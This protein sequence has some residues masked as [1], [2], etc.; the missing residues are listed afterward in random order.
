MSPIDEISN[1]NDANYI[2]EYDVSYINNLCRITPVFK[3][4]LR[5]DIIYYKPDYFRM[6]KSFS[7]RN[8]LL[9]VIIK[10]ANK[11]Y[12]LNPNV[13]LSNYDNYGDNDICFDQYK[14]DA[15]PQSPLYRL[16]KRSIQHMQPFSIRITRYRILIDYLQ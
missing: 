8:N 9:Y 1:F 10:V 13:L 3:N 4:N 11:R 2:L 5:N 7:D 12:I 6:F 16:C 15:Y 14:I